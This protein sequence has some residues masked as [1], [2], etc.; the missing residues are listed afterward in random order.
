MSAP[1]TLIVPSRAQLTDKEACLVR[2]AGNVDFGVCGRFFHVRI[3]VVVRVGVWR[4]KERRV[5]A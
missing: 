4:E 2:A 1:R 5:V 3:V